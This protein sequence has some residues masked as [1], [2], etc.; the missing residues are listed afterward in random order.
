M[1]RSGNKKRLGARILLFIILVL[2]LIAIAAI[3]V[4]QLKNSSTS[5]SAS[6]STDISSTQT[7]TSLSSA[8]KS[9]SA[10]SDTAGIQS[11]NTKSRSDR[12]GSQSDGS[13][14]TK[15]EERS[16]ISL[17][18]SQMH[19]GDLILVSS[20]YAYDFDANASDID[21]VTIKSAQTFSYPVDK[22]DF[23]ISSRVMDQMDK[24]IKACDDAVGTES[25][26][27]SI[28]SAYRSKEYQQKVWDEAVQTNGEDYAKQYVAVPGY[29][30]HHTGLAVDFGITNS[31]GTAGSFSGSQNAQWMDENSWRYGFVRRYPT[32]K[33][34]ITGISNESWHFRFVGVPHAKLMHE[35][36]YVLEEYL[37][38]LK[39]ETTAANPAVV[40]A[41]QITYHIWYT[42]DKKIKKPE[43]SYTISGNNIDGYIITEKV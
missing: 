13:D 11:E 32:D 15:E 5:P 33:V 19:T 31:D 38:Y 35:K 1:K 34:S 24:M 7:D 10:Q 21:L 8:Q 36:G 39:K 20:K 4:R 41:D 9:R 37:D 43:H 28:S 26:Q 6:S 27:T 3:G 16:Y 30:E 14:R 23:Q 22:D 42:S 25:H 12:V 17:S 18:E 2:I 40:T 29:S